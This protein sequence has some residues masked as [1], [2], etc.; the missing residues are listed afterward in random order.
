MEAFLRELG[1]VASND[2]ATY[3]K[4]GAAWEADARGI[5]ILDCKDVQEVWDT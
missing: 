1:A 2:L 4:E 5:Y 3:Q